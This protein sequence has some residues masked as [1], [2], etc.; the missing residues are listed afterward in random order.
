MDGVKIKSKNSQTFIKKQYG[1]YIIENVDQWCSLVN[2][3]ECVS[4]ENNVET[5]VDKYFLYNQ[6]YIINK[7]LDFNNKLIKPLGSTKYPFTGNLNGNNKC[8]K[9]INIRNNK[10]NGLFGVVKNSNI[11]N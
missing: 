6:H 1:N 8:L 11:Q 3:D 7:D 5:N 10:K 2:C 4:V 9:N